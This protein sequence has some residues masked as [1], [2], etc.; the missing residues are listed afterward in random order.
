VPGR[1]I[2]ED[3]GNLFAIENDPQFVWERRMGRNLGSGDALGL[4]QW[5]LAAAVCVGLVLAVAM[6]FRQTPACGFI[7]FD[8]DEYVYANSD[9]T[10]GLSPDG[11]VWALNTTQ[12]CNWHPLTWLSLLLDYQLYGWEPWGYHLTNVLLH[13]AVAIGLFLVLRRITGDL[14]PSAFAAAVFAVHPLRVESVAWVAER[15]DVLSGLFFVLTLWAY[16]G[17]VRRPPSL[18]RYSAVFVLLALGLMAKPMLVTLPFVLLLLDYWPLR[19]MAD[20]RSAR[21]LVL[22]KLPLA[23]LSLASCIVTPLAQGPAVQSMAKYSLPLRIA[24]ALVAC[25][26]YI[27]QLFYPVGLAVYYPF[28]ENGVP[29]WQVIGA[30][31]LLASI[32][33]A[34][35]VWRRRRPYL[36]VGW[37]W[38]LGM[39]VPVIGL[40][41]VGG[42]SMADRYTYLPQIGLLIAL[43]WAAKQAVGAWSHRAWVCW[44]AAGLI[45]VMLIAAASQQ[46]S[47]WRNSETVWNRVLSCGPQNAIAH[48]NL[49]VEIERQGRVPEAVAHYHRVIELDPRNAEAHNNL[50]G[51][52]LKQTRFDESV[53]EYREALAID[54]KYANAHSNFGVALLRQGHTSE[55]MD[56]FRQ[57]Q[58]L[59]PQLAAAHYNLGNALAEQEKLDEA[60]VEYGKALKL[61]PNY[62]DAHHRLGT[63][64][65]EAGKIRESLPQL[66]EAI[67]LRPDSALFLSQMAWA[68]ATCPEV[69][70]RNGA[71]AVILAQEA[72]RLTGGNDA[73]FLDILAAA[74]AESGRFA[75]AVATIERALAKASDQNGSLN[76]NAIRARLKLY[77]AGSA[78]HQIRNQHQPEAPARPDRIASEA[79]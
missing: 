21:A 45:V 1:K 66:A 50:G 6:V 41:Q 75:E 58:Q 55:A 71:K 67:R 30:F 48:L 56:Q 14:W 25:V 69:S 70:V 38:Y 15:K 37:F 72:V 54:P 16:S 78:Y 23:A 65:Y 63:V 24:N 18:V 46:V 2:A 5:R 73:K 8:D 31:I 61:Q 49:G 43:T 47:Y 57:A 62:A 10:R 4:R 51:I 13:A 79:G 20:W 9:L 40:V 17:Y 35:V 74:Y 34:A 36:T 32:S 19:R 26:S 7:N 59:D 27:G 53:A 33:V 22:E 3:V 12:A 77:Q 44:P 28:P 42:Q 64:L 52:L 39:L 68:L 76:T 29:H 11:I 60:V